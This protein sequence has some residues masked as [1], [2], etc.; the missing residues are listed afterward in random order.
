M[1]NIVAGKGYGEWKKNTWRIA[2]FPAI[3]DRE[4]IQLFKVLEKYV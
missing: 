2:N 4:F 3:E 1:N